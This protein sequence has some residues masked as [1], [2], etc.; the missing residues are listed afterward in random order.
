MMPA[1]TTRSTPGVPSATSAARRASGVSGLCWCRAEM[2]PRWLR[3]SSDR[4]VPTR[5]PLTRLSLRH[6]SY[7]SE[8]PWLGK[9]IVG[10]TRA[11]KPSALRALAAR[12]IAGNTRGRD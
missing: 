6:T 12:R 7:G 4:V 11:H 5:L 10:R 2:T 9:G 1:A 8:R 3:P